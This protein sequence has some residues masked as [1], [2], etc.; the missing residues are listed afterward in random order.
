M[1]KA[2]LKKHHF[3]ILFGL[4]PLLVLIAVIT[5][6][7]GVGAA[8]E[9]KQADIKKSQDEI[10][11]KRNAKGNELIAK[12]DKRVA[13]LAGKRTELWES[14]WN[15]QRP[16]FTWPKDRDGLLTRLNYDDKGG[17]LRFGA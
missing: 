13:S 11:A 10:A 9:N 7:S 2:T 5:I 3:W 14:N 4:V 1:N 6:S 8:I 15:K 16:L 17:G 12:M